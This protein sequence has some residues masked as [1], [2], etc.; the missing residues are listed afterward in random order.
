[1]PFQGSEP[2]LL[3]LS[4][5][6]RVLRVSPHTIRSFTRSGRLSPVRICRRLLFTPESVQRLIE[7]GSGAPGEITQPIQVGAIPG[8]QQ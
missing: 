1:M 4:E 5:V 8:R 6:A 3:T 7:S 2:A